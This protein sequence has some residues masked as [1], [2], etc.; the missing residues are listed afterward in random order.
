MKV[1]AIVVTYNGSKWINK[2]FASL[3][4]STIPLKVLVIDNL[5]TDGTTDLIQNKFPQVEVIKAGQNLGFGKA[6]NI[7][8]KMALENNAD[9]VFLLNQDAWVEPDTIE[10]LINIQFQHP[11]FH[12][13]SPIHL[14]GSGDAI[15][16]HF[17]VYLGPEHTAGFYSD[18]YLGKL[19]PFY[20]GKYANAAAWLLTHHC[21]EIVGGFDTLFNH[22]GE[23]DD[24]IQR[25]HRCNLKLAIVSNAV[26]Y[27][28]RLQTNSR[29]KI[30]N[31]NLAYT[32]ALKLLK[33]SKTPK[34]HF[35]F[36]LIIADIFTF[37]FVYFG[38][39]E[40]LKT[41]IKSLYFAIKLK[42][43]V[44]HHLNHNI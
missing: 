43:K 9:Y 20:Q 23:D 42:H 29:S 28:D 44:S 30:F 3:L 13:L 6:N 35:L 24:F 21:L 7:G 16:R 18:L 25:F 40:M 11:Q 26:I 8:L 14:N 1:Y 17:Q 15:D 10:K 38:K 31:D 19:K 22:Y 2:C 41:K 34:Y 39:N 32:Q 37:I 12:L 36:R 33:G 5:S 4:N 27:H